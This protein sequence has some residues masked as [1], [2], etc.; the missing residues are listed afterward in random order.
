MSFSL[1]KVV[2]QHRGRVF[3]KW[4][5]DAHSP[6]LSSAAI[7]DIDGDGLMEV[8]F[9]TKDG[10]V[11]CLDHEARE[12]WI[13][14][15][16]EKVSPGDE[17]FYD[18]DK[19]HA[20]SSAPVLADINADG[21]K[22]IVVGTDQGTLYVFS[23][24]GKLLWK[25]QIGG[26]IRAS[27]KVVD[28]NGDGQPEILVS[29]TNRKVMVLNP[30][31]EV[32]AS[33]K[34]RGP[35]TCTPAVLRGERGKQS[36]II[37]G[38][39]D[40]EVIAMDTQERALW[41]F[42]TQGRVTAEP[43]IIRTKTEALVVVGSWDGT[44]YALRPSGELVWRFKTEG[45]ISS[46]AQIVDVNGDGVAEIVFGSCD[47]KV[48]ALSLKGERLWTYETD[49]WVVA[50]P[51]VADIDGDGNIEVVAGSYDNH[52]YVL[53]GAGSYDL[54]FVPG[55]SGL[56]QQSGHY[57]DV[58]SKE[59]GRLHGKRIWQY[60]TRGMVVGCSLIEEGRPALVI[61]VKSGFIDELKHQ[62]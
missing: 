50:S 2:S 25:K 54:D 51:L 40:G 18:L 34:A 57:S 56:V 52:V 41:T 61:N 6:L 44:L 55:L 45:A 13:F 5:F 47:N 3:E 22:E 39:D 62:E 11:Y 14:R 29:S 7:A 35:V 53:E 36:I 12:R 43:A 30:S 4:V 59:P 23:C 48:Y 49:F 46:K 28:L 20:I 10:A 32:L 8:V 58:L 27:P 31:G 17:Y 24:D 21:K 19:L 26:A 37:F 16:G 42:Q 60:R 9:G 15:T 1:R 33:F 38:T